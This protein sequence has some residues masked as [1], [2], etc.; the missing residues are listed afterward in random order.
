MPDE[1]GFVDASVLRCDYDTRKKFL[2]KINAYKN[3]SEQRIFRQTTVPASAA[4]NE[5][6]HAIQC[7]V[8]NSPKTPERIMG[9]RL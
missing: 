2:S 5:A 4:A 6:Y 9:K 8:K 1:K 3:R 7:D